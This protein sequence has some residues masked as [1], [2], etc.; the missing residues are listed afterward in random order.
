[1]AQPFR[2]YPE[3][4]ADTK[5]TFRLW[6]FLRD[7][8]LN[9]PFQFTGLVPHFVLPF[10]LAYLVLKGIGWWTNE[11]DYIVDGIVIPLLQGLSVGGIVTMGYMRYG[12]PAGRLVAKKRSDSSATSDEDTSQHRIEVALWAYIYLGLA[13]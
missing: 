1:M 11:V 8:I 6:P 5:G 13:T 3:P 2:P 4:G 9:G 12:T 7:T 10:Y